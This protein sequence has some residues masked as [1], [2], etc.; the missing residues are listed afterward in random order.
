MIFRPITCEIVDA[1]PAAIDLYGYSWKELI[2]GGP[3]LFLGPE[4]YKEFK[5]LLRAAGSSEGFCMFPATHT[6]KDGRRLVVTVSAKNIL[7]RE[8]EHNVIY[9][10]FFDITEKVHLQEEVKLRQAQLIHADKM[11][12]LGTMVSGVAHE[13]NNPNNFIISNA[14]LI[15][16]IFQDIM[17]ILAE[18]QREYGNLSLGR[19]SFSEVQDIIPK[20]L[21]GII[22][23]SRR[24]KNIIENLKDFSRPD[25]GTLDEEVDINRAVEAAILIINNQIRRHCSNFHVYLGENLPCIKGSMQKIEQVIINLIQNA[26]QFLPNRQCRVWV[27][28]SF[29]E[30]DHSVVIK[31]KDEGIGI[32]DDIIGRIVEPFF[33]TRPDKGGIGLGLSISYYIV[34][35]HQGTLEFESKPGRGTTAIVKLPVPETEVRG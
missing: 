15:Q 18:Y 31:I 20:L 28:T 16:D 12:S 10:T 3:A 14:Q 22:D 2:E 30:K 35:E 4:L 24:I 32:S 9:C 17:P 26:L 1:N 33:T 21:Q 8:W 27:S 23:G 29:I 11:T 5:Q 6:R 34:K 19:L 13:I 25:R 7:M